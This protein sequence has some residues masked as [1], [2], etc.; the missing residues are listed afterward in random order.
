MFSVRYF[1]GIKSN[2]TSQRLFASCI[3]NEFLVNFNFFIFWKEEKIIF[4]DNRNTNLFSK[5]LMGKAWLYIYTC[6]IWQWIFWCPLISYTIKFKA[7]F[8]NILL[9]VQGL[10][11]GLSWLSAVRLVCLKQYISVMY[12]W[13]GIVYC[14]LRKIFYFMFYSTFI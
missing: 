3:K 10:P 8:S 4:R 6:L 13:A 12:D 2:L 5:L 7:F 14:A 11:V 1:E 9:I